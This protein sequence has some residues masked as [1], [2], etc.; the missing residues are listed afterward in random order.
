MLHV[1]PSDGRNKER[2][3]HYVSLCQ[4]RLS[5]TSIKFLH[6]DSALNMGRKALILQRNTNFLET[7]FIQQIDEMQGNVCCSVAYV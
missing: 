3:D 1:H 7:C 5:Q 2:V 4:T 6:H